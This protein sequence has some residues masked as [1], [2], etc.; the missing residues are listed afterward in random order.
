MFLAL[1]ALTRLTI[2]GYFWRHDCY[3]AN[4]Y[5]DY[6]MISESDMGNGLRWTDFV[7]PQGK[8]TPVHHHADG[9][10]LGTHRGLLSLDFEHSQRAIPSSY[11][12][13][14]PSGYPHGMR[15]HGAFD[16]WSLYIR[17][18]LTR[19]LP[20][21]PKTFRVEGLLREALKRVKSWGEE[22]VPEQA[23]G[24]LTQVILDEIRT[25]PAAALEL[26]MPQD[27]R[28]MRL[29]R[30]LLSDVSVQ[31]REEQ[32][33]EYAGLSV[34][35]LVR[36]FPA[37]TGLTFTAWRQRA[38]MMRAMELL[39]QGMAVQNVAL[40]VGYDNASAFIAV[41]RRLS[42]TTPGHYF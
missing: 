5:G 1:V 16:G 29:V 11:A 3:Q 27:P 34:R 7:E 25:L 9:Q 4:L 21:T 23:R 32:W 24:A 37:Q 14:V 2:E 41:F 38:R 30:R 40:E 39:A 33:A 13:W 18:D 6:A 22:S 15:S 28:L 17:G 35:T 20:Q 8:T 36:L 31:L 42:G 26:P 12:V 19:E 10:L